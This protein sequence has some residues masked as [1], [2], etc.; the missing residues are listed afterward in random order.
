[1]C[2]CWATRGF[3]HVISCSPA[4]AIQHVSALQQQIEHFDGSQQKQRT[5]Q[6]APFLSHNISLGKLPGKLNNA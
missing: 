2:L 5:C 6:A 3:S 1:M 4:N